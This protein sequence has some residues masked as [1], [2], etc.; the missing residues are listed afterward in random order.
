MGAEPQVLLDEFHSTV[1]ALDD[2]DPNVR[3]EAQEHFN[4]VAHEIEKRKRSRNYRDTSILPTVSRMA[5][6]YDAGRA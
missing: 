3:Y 6:Q 5:Q 2:E 4:K 1:E